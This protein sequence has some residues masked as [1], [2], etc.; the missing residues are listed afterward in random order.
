MAAAGGTLRTN[1]VC[2]SVERAGL[3][4]VNRGEIFQPGRGY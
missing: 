4:L 3:G 1:A 2:W